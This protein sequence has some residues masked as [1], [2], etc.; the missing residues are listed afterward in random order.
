MEQTLR[1]ERLETG[2]SLLVGTQI[3]VLEDEFEVASLITSA[4]ET[5][6]GSVAALVQDIDSA[7]ETIRTTE[8]SAAIITMIADGIYTDIV[9]QELSARG[10]PFAVTTGIG[11]DR[12][13]P[14]LHEAL[15][16]IKPFQAAH[17]QRI[18]AGLLGRDAAAS[19]PG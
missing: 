6:G 5:A 1:T 10:I 18:V 13:H 17:M 3:L 15:T 8:V 7:L 14:A 11:T 2:T 12:R 4:I 9:A 16:I 19:T